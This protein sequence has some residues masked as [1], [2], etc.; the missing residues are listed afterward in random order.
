MIFRETLEISVSYFITGNKTVTD[1]GLMIIYIVWNNANA[2]LEI[3]KK[4][5]V[6]LAVLSLKIRNKRDDKLWRT[7]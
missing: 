3:K 1:E 7:K 2:F 4:K 6:Y 5:N